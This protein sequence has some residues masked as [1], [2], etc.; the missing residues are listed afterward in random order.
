MTETITSKSGKT[1]LV[2][3]YGGYVAIAY[4]ADN[5]DYE[6]LIV[7]NT[8]KDCNC[9]MLLKNVFCILKDDK[10]SEHMALLFELNCD[11]DI[12]QVREYLYAK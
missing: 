10:N 8:L 9:C 1:F 3:S 2:K 4:I 12:I 6:R 7:T 11:R 5:S